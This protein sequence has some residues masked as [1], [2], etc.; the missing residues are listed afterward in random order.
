MSVQFEDERTVRRQSQ[1]ILQIEKIFE[2]R[3]AQNEI[4][5]YAP[6]VPDGSNSKATMLLEFPDPHERRRE[7]A[8]MVGAE[9]RRFVEVEE[10]DRVYAIADEHL[11]RE[12][13][14]RTSSVHCVR[15]DFK[16]A[17]S[18][19]IRAGAVVKLG[20]D[21]MHYPAH[22]QIDTD[23]LASLAGDFR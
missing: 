23:T 19:A 11:G 22:V 7:L 2:E 4:V 5:A 8:R 10:H 20:C 17:M 3:R 13:E 16:P 1:E 21:H 12:S 14:A 18:L 6:F 15:F 9:E